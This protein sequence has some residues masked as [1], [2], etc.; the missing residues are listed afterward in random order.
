M[1]KNLT[2]QERLKGKALINRVFSARTRVKCTGA[3]L[4]YIN[5]GLEIN[6]VLF[7]FV[8]KFGNAVQRNRA[9]RVFKEIYRNMKD[10]LRPGYDMIFILFPGNFDYS[11]RKTQAESLLQKASLFKNGL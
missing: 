5:N 8:R 2:R 11:V 10:S 6:R 1:R 7:T 3:K 4:I 9:K